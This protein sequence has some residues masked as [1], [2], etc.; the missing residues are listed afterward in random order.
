MLSAERDNTN[1][2]DAVSDSDN[3]NNVQISEEGQSTAQSASNAIANSVTGRNT[4]VIV[5]E[6]E[7]EKSLQAITMQAKI[8]PSHQQLQ[9]HLL[10]QQQQARIAFSLQFIDKVANRF[11]TAPSIYR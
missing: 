8:M 7:R 1:I 6:G 9:D 4:P 11:A 3:Q 10:R 5:P 2:I